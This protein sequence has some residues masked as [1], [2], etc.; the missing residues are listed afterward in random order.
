MADENVLQNA[1]EFYQKIKA[2]EEVTVKFRKIDGTERI[3]KCTLDFSKIPEGKRPKDVDMGKIFSLV[4][5]H[6]MVHVFD[7][8]KKDWRTVP[9]QRSEWVE[10]PQRV[11]FRIKKG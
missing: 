2:E 4:Q 9:F 3:M 7:L 5:K 8:E 10:T 1:I 11:R 6:G